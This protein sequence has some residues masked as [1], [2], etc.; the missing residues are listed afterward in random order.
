[1]SEQVSDLP[2][3]GGIQFVY[4]ELDLDAI[5]GDAAGHIVDI[6][7]QYIEIVYFWSRVPR[8]L[9][10]NFVCS[11]FVLALLEPGGTKHTLIGL[12][13]IDNSVSIV[14]KLIMS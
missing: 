12:A 13:K 5:S 6:W 9:V 11:K 7:K 14:F 8:W 1:M 4:V 10:T 3:R 2:G